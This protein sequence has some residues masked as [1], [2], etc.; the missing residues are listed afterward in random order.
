MSIQTSRG[1]TPALIAQNF[2][3]GRYYQSIAEKIYSYESAVQESILCM[4]KEGEFHPLI[5]SLKP[6]WWESLLDA[7]KQVFYIA[8]KSDVEQRNYLHRLFYRG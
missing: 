6:A 5:C 8:V 4:L 7:E 3:E 1:T 2:V